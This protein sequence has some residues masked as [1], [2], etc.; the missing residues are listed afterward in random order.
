MSAKLLV[1]VALCCGLMMQACTDDKRTPE[2]KALDE[3][4]ECAVNSYQELIEGDYEAFLNQRADFETMTDDY[5]EQLTTAYKQFMH[6]QQKEHG[7]IQSV[8][9]TNARIDSSL[10]KIMVFLMLNY[11]DSLQEEIVIPMVEHNG[12]WKLK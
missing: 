6:E 10:N 8:K 2:E 12:S 9:V 5:R 11:A 7:G 4:K 1:M 3:A